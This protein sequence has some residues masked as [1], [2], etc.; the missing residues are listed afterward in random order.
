M[1]DVYDILKILTALYKSD[2]DNFDAEYCEITYR[3]FCLYADLME[4]LGVEANWKIK[5]AYGTGI[6]TRTQTILDISEAESDYELS[7]MILEIWRRYRK[8][9][10]TT[11][12]FM[13]IMVQ[14]VESSW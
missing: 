5:V 9:E 6:G 10:Y 11:Q 14:L 13:D 4:L 2:P 1:D 3:Y 7:V 8:Q 12:Q